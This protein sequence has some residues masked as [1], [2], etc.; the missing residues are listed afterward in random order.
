MSVK[1][2]KNSLFEPTKLI[3]IGDV[4]GEYNHLESLL[5]KLLPL[6]EGTHLVFCGD[7]VDRGRNSA[8]VLDIITG[9]VEKYPGQIFCVRGNHDWMLQ[10]YCLTG[11][12]QW[13]NFIGLTLDQMKDEWNL[14]DILPATIKQALIEQGIWSWYFDSILP[15]YETKDVIVTHA[16]LD[17]MIV[18]L[19][20]AR[21]YE[22]DLIENEQDPDVNFKY[23]LDRFNYELM[24]QFIVEPIKKIF[25]IYIWIGSTMN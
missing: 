17:Y 10:N 15:Y 16:P 23:L 20:G 13:F 12:R 1:Y 18:T 11:S 2:G 3:A 21:D 24:W 7:L 22:Q 6:E 25:K 5:T 14:P 8:R 9:L 4:H 19:N